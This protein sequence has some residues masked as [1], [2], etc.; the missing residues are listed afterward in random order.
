MKPGWNTLGLAAQGNTFTI[1]LNGKT[2]CE[3][4]DQQIQAAGKVGLWTKADSV[5]LFDDFVIDPAK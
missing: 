3:V 1:Q 4:E 5:M 2:L